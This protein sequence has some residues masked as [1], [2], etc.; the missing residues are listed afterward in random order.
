MYAS[1]VLFS[2]AS[3]FVWS[4]A[5]QH[6]Q[7]LQYLGLIVIVVFRFTEFDVNW[8]LL[9]NTNWKFVVEVAESVIMES[10]LLD[11]IESSRGTAKWEH[12]TEYGVTKAVEIL[13]REM[14]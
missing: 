11:F 3:V 7:Y 6:S 14:V 12:Y 9:C 2:E 5:V 10:A 1:N 13:P 4:V 8:Q